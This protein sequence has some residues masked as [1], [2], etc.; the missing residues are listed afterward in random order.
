M[1]ATAIAPG[2]AGVAVTPCPLAIAKRPGW[3]GSAA[4]QF[5]GKGVGWRVH[6]APSSRLVSKIPHGQLRPGAA[7]AA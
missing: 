2:S 3:P 4:V 5:A 1:V 6:V 7:D